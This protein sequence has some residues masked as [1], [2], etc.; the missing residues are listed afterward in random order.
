M[1]EKKKAGHRRNVWI[2]IITAFVVL[3]LVSY[4]S[5]SGNG[6]SNA[7]SAGPKATY[8][9]KLASN[10]P[11]TYDASCWGQDGTVWPVNPA[12]LRVYAVVTNTGSVAGRPI[13]TI[14]AHDASYTYTGTDTVQAKSPLK[15]GGQSEFSDDLTIAHQGSQYVTNL[16]IKCH[17]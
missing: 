14:Q 13:C 11:M 4:I 8:S 16:A 7:S 12:D 17:S 9:A 3:W 1:A 15:P 10:C 6:A 2:V 5:S